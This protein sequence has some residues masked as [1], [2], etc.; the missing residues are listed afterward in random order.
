MIKSKFRGLYD[1]KRKRVVTPVIG[2]TR[3]KQ[4]F[5]DECNID[6]ILAQYDRTG[7]INHV[8]EYQGNYEDVSNFQDYHTSMN[9]V[10]E[11]N[12]LFM[13]LPSKMRLKFNND[14]GS[15]VEFVSNPEN[16]EEMIKMGLIN[17]KTINSAE[18]SKKDSEV[19]KV[20]EK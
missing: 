20:D 16:K 12:K 18:D 13:T 15:F 2:D 6:N 19:V 1:G 7:L 3:T 17:E 4:Y 5:K 10:L 14:P 9:Q 8:N 11:T